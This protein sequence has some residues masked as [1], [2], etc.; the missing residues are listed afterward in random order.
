MRTFVQKPKATLAANPS[1]LVMG[2]PRLSGPGR[3]W[4]PLQRSI[5]NQAGERPPPSHGHELEAEAP[6]SAS[7]RF[8][9][10]FSRIS[11][12]AGAPAILQTKLQVN[13]PGD[14]YEQEA[15][16]VAEHVMR[17]PDPGAWVT[18]LSHDAP[19]TSLKYRVRHWPSMVKFACC[20]SRPTAGAA[21]AGL[22]RAEVWL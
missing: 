1:S 16:R 13:T 11:L 14:T 19:A 17:M 3:Y 9:H 18:S 7:P 20:R 8:A 12:H 15:D 10:D 22:L 2:R 6:A 21:L 4:N 5:A